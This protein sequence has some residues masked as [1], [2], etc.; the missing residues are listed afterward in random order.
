MSASSEEI[1]QP[2]ASSIRANWRDLIGWVAALPTRLA[3]VAGG[4]R[5]KKRRGRRRGEKVFNFEFLR[6]FSENPLLF[7]LLTF[8][9]ND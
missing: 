1:F 9:L 7:F 5:S 8:E 4:R 2:S 3:A 6:L